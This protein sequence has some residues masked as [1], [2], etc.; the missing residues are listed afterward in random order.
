M[1]EQGEID[2]IRTWLNR[3]GTCLLLAPHHDVGFTDDMKQ[4]QME[5]KHHGDELVPRQQRFGQ[6]TRSLMQGLGVPVLNQFGLRLAFVP[7][8]DQIAPLTTNKDLDELGL[9]NG[10]TTFNFHLHLPHYALTTEDTNSVRVLA[11]QP[12]DL[13]R[14][15]PFTAAGNREFN[16]FLWIPPQGGRGG[17]IPLA[18]STIFTTLFGGTDSL[19]HFWRNMANLRVGV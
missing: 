19:G 2:A 12:I 14:P 9:L 1:S 17:D 10:V 8:T 4:R 18:D 11:T 6:Y 3:E 5:Y 13:S 7:G 16:S 15:H